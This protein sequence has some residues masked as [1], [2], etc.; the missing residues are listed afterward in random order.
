MCVPDRPPPGFS[1]KKK[2]RK[3]KNTGVERFESYVA[4]FLQSRDSLGDCAGP[5]KGSRAGQGM[6]ERAGWVDLLIVVDA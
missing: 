6:G 4:G 2:T 1:L 5:E 3:G